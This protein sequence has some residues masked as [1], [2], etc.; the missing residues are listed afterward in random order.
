MQTDGM[1]HNKNIGKY[2][3]KNYFKSVNSKLYNPVLQKN[4]NFFARQKFNAFPKS[5]I[6]SNIYI[7]SVIPGHFKYYTIQKNAN[8]QSKE[9]TSTVDQ[10]DKKTQKN[11]KEIIIDEKNDPKQSEKIVFDIISEWQKKVPFSKKPAVPFFKSYDPQKRNDL[12]NKEGQIKKMIDSWWWLPGAIATLLF[13]EEKLK[14]KLEEKKLISKEPFDHIQGP[15]AYPKELYV[16]ALDGNMARHMSSKRFIEKLK[17]AGLTI[18]DVIKIQCQIQEDAAYK[19]LIL[20]ANLSDN[21]C[22][23]LHNILNLRYS[24]FNGDYNDKN[25]SF[26]GNFN[27]NVKQMVKDALRINNIPFRVT[28]HANPKGE[29]DRTLGS[30]TIKDKANFSFRYNLATGT[31]GTVGKSIDAKI[32]L[33]PTTLKSPEQIIKLV[34]AHEVTHTANLDNLTHLFFRIYATKIKKMNQ[35]TYD[36]CIIILNTIFEYQADIL[37]L[38]HP[39]YAKAQEFY[40][41]KKR[42]RRDIYV[43]QAKMLELAERAVQL[44]E[45]EKLMNKNQN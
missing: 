3:K 2:I 14:E 28:I 44:H 32:Y 38:K 12:Q 26:D 18:E 35:S 27:E 15:P 31:A 6:N 41:K 21:D 7:N 34:I 39:E 22:I 17:K 1:K 29:D 20:T 43:P 13:L 40:S 45:T 36:K 30:T 11:Q 8:D 4:Y 10:E 9:T 42:I 25:I 24:F 33:S 37:P 19:E 5:I 16:Y 23:L